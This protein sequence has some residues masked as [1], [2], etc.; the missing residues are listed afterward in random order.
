MTP[1][2]SPQSEA[3]RWTV[4]REKASPDGTSI[5]F[6]NLKD[7]LL[8]WTLECRNEAQAIEMAESL[9]AAPAARELLEA[10]DRHARLSGFGPN[11]AFRSCPS[12]PTT[13]IENTEKPKHKAGC[14]YAPLVDAAEALRERMGK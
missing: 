3:P 12:C 14:T 8:D 11:S 7:N 2:S 5:R 4:E 6:W 9:N 13:W 1:P 10:V